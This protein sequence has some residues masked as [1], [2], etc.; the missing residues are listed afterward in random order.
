MPIVLRRK[1]PG[2]RRA[3]LVG[4]CIVLY[5]KYIYFNSGWKDWL[6]E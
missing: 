6:L 3:E 4:A 2:I 5:G 1:A